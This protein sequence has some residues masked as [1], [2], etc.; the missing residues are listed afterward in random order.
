MTDTVL[1]HDQ[2]YIPSALAGCRV[3][4]SVAG[5]TALALATLRK[6]LAARNG[7]QLGARDRNRLIRR[8]KRLGFNA[9]WTRFVL[10]AQ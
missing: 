2:C 4:F 7:G 5:E 3:E 6:S 8:C 9:V 10:G 1:V